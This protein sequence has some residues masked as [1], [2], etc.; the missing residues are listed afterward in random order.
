MLLN[1]RFHLNLQ[2]GHIGVP[3]TL[4]GTSVKTGCMDTVTSTIF[5]SKQLTAY[6][7]FSTQSLQI[8][9]IQVRCANTHVG[10]QQVELV[11]SLFL[12]TPPN[13][14]ACHKYNRS[15][16]SWPRLISSGPSKAS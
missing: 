5:L 12:S 11:D 9:Q 8:Y 1:P 15:L 14:L 7:L 3:K 13:F 6:T 2:K 16:C 4:V 10:L